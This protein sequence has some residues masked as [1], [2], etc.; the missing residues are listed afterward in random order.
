MCRRQKVDHAAVF[1]LSPNEFREFGETEQ[2]KLN[3]FVAAVL[4]GKVT[5]KAL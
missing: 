3:D 4:D 1:D 2:A 5:P